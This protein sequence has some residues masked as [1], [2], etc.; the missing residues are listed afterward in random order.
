VAN[1]KLSRKSRG[2]ST[3][4]GEGFNPS[5]SGINEKPEEVLELFGDGVAKGEMKKIVE[6]IIGHIMENAIDGA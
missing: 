5:P 1:K 2:N 4:S 6:R 3:V